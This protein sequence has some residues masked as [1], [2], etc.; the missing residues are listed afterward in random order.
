MALRA[1]PAPI[2]K[3][4]GTHSNA[5]RVGRN[6]SF[7]LAAQV[8]YS[9][10]NVAAMVLLGNALAARGYGE[11]AFYYALIPLIAAASD[12]GVGIILTRGIARDHASGSRLLGDALVIKAAVSGGILVAALLVAWTTLDPTRAALFSIV[13][14]TALMVHGQDPAVWVFRAREK[15][16][17]EAM[18]LLL[19]QVIWL[20]L[21]ALGVVAKVGLVWLLAAA[22]AAYVVRLMTGMSLVMWR[23]YR[24]EFHPERARLR[25]LLVEGLPF[26]AATFGTVLYTQVG[27]LMLKGIATPVDVAYFNVAYMLSQP[28]SF[29][30]SVMGIAVFPMIARDARD[31]TQALRRDLT[32]NAK[33]QALFAAPLAVGLFL[34]ARP[35]VSLMFHGREFE[36]AVTGLEVM[37]IGLPLSFLNVSFRY[38]LAALDHQRQ[39]FHAILAGL[40]ANAALC[41]VLIPRFGFLGACV[42]FLG[43]EAIIWAVC[44]RTLS[45]H[46]GLREQAAEAVKP[47][48][49]ALGMGLVVF[50]LHAA[51]VFVRVAAGCVSYPALL[52]LMRAFSA[53]EMRVLRRLYASFRLPGA[54]LVDRRGPDS[55][56]AVGSEKPE[57]A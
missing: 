2:G 4:T 47:L 14:V 42:A 13:A 28:F 50:A 19:S 53:E 51:N 1:S 34:L 15:L 56:E 57:S 18:M 40:I 10:I 30:A 12:G 55:A 48:L 16:H 31:G 25:Q 7:L 27:L 54:G 37:S 44:H 6:A 24:P 3:S 32:L 35:I 45:R 21:L 38:V 22:T 36:P 41:A 29:I 20:P 23:L 9:L 46:A 39:Y 11:Y 49:A 5:L 52:F 33:W 8:V 17:L 43:A 26:G